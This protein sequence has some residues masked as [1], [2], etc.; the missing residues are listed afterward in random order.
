MS[1]AL[2]VV[3]PHCDAINRLPLDRPAGA[4]KCGKCKGALFEAHPLELD[5]RRFPQHLNIRDV[6][7]GVA[8]WARGWGP[9]RQVAAAQ[10]AIRSI[11][12]L[13]LLHHGREIAR[14]AGA[15]DTRSLIAWVAQHLSQI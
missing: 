1:S 10:Y 3:C 9:C 4:G 6:P 12:T 15:M 14:V 11:P 13:M 2:H 8:F 5:G 7:L